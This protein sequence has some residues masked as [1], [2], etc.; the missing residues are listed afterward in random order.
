MCGRFTQSLSLSDVIAK[1]SIV[2]VAST[3]LEADTKD[4]SSSNIFQNYNLAPSQSALVVYDNSQ[5]KTSLSAATFGTK[6]QFGRN[7]T[8]TTL[9]NA[10]SETV[11]SKP[12]FSKAFKFRRCI[13]PANGY[14]E[15]ATS[16]NGTKTPYYITQNQT[17]IISI[18]GLL[19]DIEGKSAQGFVLLTQA[20]N[21]DISHIHDRMPV[22]IPE[23]YQNPWLDTLATD[24][25]QLQEVLLKI[26]TIN[27]CQNR[28]FYEVSR[29]V[30]S[31]TYNSPAAILPLFDQNH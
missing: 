11:A 17:P 22:F 10:R 18:A 25:H 27:E 14:F 20:A 23:P 15:W 26:T 2:T 19:Y 1:Y 21:K 9:I 4:P 30:G 8:A 28:S 24:P 7:A 5:T 3:L 6:F 13:V 31:P 16:N 29:A 12:T